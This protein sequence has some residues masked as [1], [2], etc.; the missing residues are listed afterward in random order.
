MLFQFD[1]LSS[2][3]TYDDVARYIIEDLFYETA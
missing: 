3:T 1:Y 2:V